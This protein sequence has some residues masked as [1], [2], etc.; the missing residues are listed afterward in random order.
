MR[1]GWLPHDVLQ[2]LESYGYVA[3]PKE[4]IKRFYVERIEDQY[5]LSMLAYDGSRREDYT[6]AMKRS[7]AQQMA[8]ILFEQG[9]IEPIVMPMNRDDPAMYVRQRCELTVIKPR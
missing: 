3:V 5:A 4:M 6:N 8:M 1:A 2:L 7:L 9:F